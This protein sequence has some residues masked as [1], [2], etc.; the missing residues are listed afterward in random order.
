MSD[1]ILRRL[2]D[3]EEDYFE[4]PAVVRRSDLKEINQLR[5]DLGLPQVDDRLQEFGQAVADGPVADE[6][7]PAL[8]AETPVNDYVE[9]RAI[10]E[11]WLRK[12]EELKGLQEYADQVAS[13]TGGG[14]R[15]PVR[16]LATMGRNG[17]LL[18][19]HCG[20]PMVLE[21]GRFHG[22]PADAAWKRKPRGNWK[23]YILGGMVVEIQTNGTLRIYHG[24]PSRNSTDC[25]NVAAIE[26][27]K[28]RAE[29]D[30]SAR[31]AKLP[32]LSDFIAQEFPDLAESE[33]MNLLSE[34][35]GTM[36]S[37]DPGPGINRP[38]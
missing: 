8:A 34:I 4:M 1:E 15:T 20:K 24:Y 25:C 13:A 21:G 27:E 23:S 22:L 5:A 12:T 35:V 36:F 2:S 29:F 19:D 32:I 9:A 26:E 14:G 16:P 18:C 17:P 31:A 28:A 33:R 3:L 11:D 38:A 10:Y 30:L 6:P 7:A 37:Y